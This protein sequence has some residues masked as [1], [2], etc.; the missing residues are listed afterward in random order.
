MKCPDE[1]SEQGDRRVLRFA[2]FYSCIPPEKG[3]WPK[4]N[5]CSGVFVYL[6][7]CHF[8]VEQVPNL[9]TATLSAPSAVLDQGPCQESLVL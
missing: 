8:V 5:L 6:Y 9:L 7:L 2:G 4:R 1:N 3:E